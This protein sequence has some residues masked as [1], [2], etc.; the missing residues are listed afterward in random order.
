M[1]SGKDLEPI[2]EEKA[3]YNVTKPRNGVKAKKISCKQKELIQAR[4]KF[5]SLAR[6]HFLRICCTLAKPKF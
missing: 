1:E 2:L 6:F 5:W 4:A 3:N